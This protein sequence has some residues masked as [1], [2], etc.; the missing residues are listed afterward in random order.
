MQN[1]L[2]FWL[3]D[4]PLQLL[5]NASFFIGQDFVGILSMWFVHARNA[6]RSV[7]RLPSRLRCQ[8]HKPACW[9]RHFDPAVLQSPDVRVGKPAPPLRNSAICSRDGVGGRPIASYAGITLPCVP[10]TLHKVNLLPLGRV[11]Q[12]H[13]KGL[14]APAVSR[15]RRVFIAFTD[16]RQIVP[17][18]DRN[19]AARRLRSQGPVVVSAARQSD[20]RVAQVMQHRKSV[21][22]RLLESGLPQ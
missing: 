16:R 21:E 19:P 10:S 4:R 15:L 9:N 20:P 5:R 6:V 7:H 1:R 11:L 2:P 12:F 17:Q 8:H 13:R 18:R 14:L 22:R 3:A